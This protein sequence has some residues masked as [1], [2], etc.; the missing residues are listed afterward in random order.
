[1]NQSQSPADRA[2]SVAEAIAAE[3]KPVTA[4]AIKTRAGVATDVASDAARVWNDEQA[5]L[6]AIPAAPA[7]W[8]S[9]LEALWPS[10]YNEAR[11]TFSD[12]KAGILG[13]LDIAQAEQADL[14]AELAEM[15]QDLD[16]ARLDCQRERD[17]R[18][19]ATEQ[20]S[21]LETELADARENLARAQAQAAAAEQRAAELREM[22]DAVISRMES[23]P[24][25]TR[26]RA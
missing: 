17:L 8:L 21:R 6:V 5:A 20:I 7:A 15:R 12:E 16:S 4:R 23:K 10:A 25:P 26:E 22:F 9:R 13:R 1:M 2:R 11:A 19:Q 14:T 18:E 3:G 24:D